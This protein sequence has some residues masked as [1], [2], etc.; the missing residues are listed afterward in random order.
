MR[1]SGNREENKRITMDLEVVLKSHDCPY[2]VQCMGCFITESDVWICME[3]MATCFDK[4]LKRLRQPIIEPIIGKIAV[5]VTN[6]T[7]AQ[8][9]CASLIVRVFTDC[10]SAPLPQRE[11]RCYSP[12]RET[13][14]HIVG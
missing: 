3:L 9:V 13:F 7:H 6:F 5:A 4:L 12:R 2:I 14:Q 10:K 8:I 11:A 1:R